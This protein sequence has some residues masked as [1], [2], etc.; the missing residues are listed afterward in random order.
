MPIF[1]DSGTSL[2]GMPPTNTYLPTFNF[3]TEIEKNRLVEALEKG[4]DMPL[5][6]R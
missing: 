1:Q 6:E 2:G 4:T 5:Q 3:G